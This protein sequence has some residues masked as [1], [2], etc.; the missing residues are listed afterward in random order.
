M[1]DNL[2]TTTPDFEEEDDSD[3]CDELL[4]GD[5]LQWKALDDDEAETI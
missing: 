3:C 5:N 4:F 1:V 2:N